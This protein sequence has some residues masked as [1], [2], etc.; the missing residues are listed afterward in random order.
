MNDFLKLRK[1]AERR[2]LAI[3]AAG[4]RKAPASEACKLIGA[5]SSSEEVIIKYV[6]SQA[7]R[8]GIPDDIAEQ[9]K[10]GHKR[11]EEM[12]KKVCKLAEQQQRSRPAGLSFGEVLG[13]SSLIPQVNTSAKKFGGTTFDTLSGNALAR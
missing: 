7:K 10:T 6:V 8:C 5:F 3:Q 1:E 12:Q 9:F 13:S 2:G 11:T 4:K